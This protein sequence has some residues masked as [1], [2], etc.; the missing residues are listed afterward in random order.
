[1]SKSSRLTAVMRALALLALLGLCLT[2]GALLLA[3]L[4]SSRA[5]AAAPLRPLRPLTLTAA[6]APAQPAAALETIELSGTWRFKADWNEDGMAQGWAKPEMVESE[7]RD[8]TVPGDW[9]SQGV[10]KPNPNWPPSQP[11]DGYNGYAWYRKHVSIPAEWTTGVITLRIGAI[12]DLD[13]TY[14]NGTKVGATTEGRESSQQMREYR[15]PNA[16]LKL[17]QDN[18]IAIRVFDREGKGGITDGPVELV[19]EVG[20]PAAAQPAP[21]MSP[22]EAAR[23]TETQS[24]IVKVGGDV[25]V[26]ANMKVS[27]DAVAV[28][29]SVSVEGWVQGD[30]TSVGGSVFLRPGARVDGSATAVGGTVE[31]EPGAAVAGSVTAIPVLPGSWIRHLIRG[32]TPPGLRHRGL[33][34]RHED[35]I[36]NLLVGVFVALLAVGLFR[37]RVEVMARALPLHPGRAA[38]YGVAGFVLVP[39]AL[40]V[41]ALTA[42]FVVIIL[43]VTIIGWLAIPAVP[44]ALA[45]AVLAL[46]AALFLGTAAVWLGLGRAILDG[47]GVRSVHPVAAALLGLLVLYAASQLRLVGGLI[48]AT[49]LI[50]GFGVAIMTGLGANED[51]VERRSARHRPSP[52]EPDEPP[53]P[54]APEMPPPAAGTETAP[55]PPSGLPSPA[56]GAEPEDATQPLPEQPGTQEPPPQTS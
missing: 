15:V 28:G 12:D 53:T 46:F 14:V 44:A 25:E 51:W 18:V 10:T 45:A 56:S 13:W 21:P 5:S 26:P 33:W 16:T 3:F 41:L 47:L 50:F 48:T 17:G 8:I 30:V 42:V 11:E 9:E 43:L 23:Y 20:Q 36:G 37:R 35:T 34:G 29:G 49:M 31:R 2:A 6:P 7:W 40:V 55:P 27:G 52:P 38:G 39:A 4:L 32:A 19:R 22:E 1:M 54:P 24:E